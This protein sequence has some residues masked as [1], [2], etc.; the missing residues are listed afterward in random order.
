MRPPR[1]CEADL[2][3]EVRSEAARL[4]SLYSDERLET[5][6]RA[7]GLESSLTQS[8]SPSAASTTEP[9]KP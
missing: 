9:D 6:I 3:S 7:K 5:L 8:A 4:E 2:Q 1:L